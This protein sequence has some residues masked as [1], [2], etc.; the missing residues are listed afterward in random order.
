[1]GVGNIIS[2]V[3]RR[4]FSPGGLKG[5]HETLT[6]FNLKLTRILTEGDVQKESVAALMKLFVAYE[7][8]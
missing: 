2:T 5:Y 1:M 8:L 4:A 3:Q 6:L 7:E